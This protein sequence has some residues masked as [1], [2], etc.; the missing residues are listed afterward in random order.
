[1]K[2]NAKTAFG[3][4][5]RFVKVLAAQHGAGEGDVDAVRWSYVANV[6]QTTHKDYVDDIQR[7]LESREAPTAAV[8]TADHVEF[9]SYSSGTSGKNK[10]V[11]LTLWPKVCI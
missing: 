2:H 5:Y 4:R 11:P 3:R 1:L 10:L 7:L 8:L 9:L 6:P